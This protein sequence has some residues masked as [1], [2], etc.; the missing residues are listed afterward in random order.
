MQSTIR[1][2]GFTLIELLVVIAII[3]ILAAILFPV[4]AKAREKARQTSCLSNVKQAAL[5]IVMYVQDYDEIMVRH[6]YQPPVGG[7]YS[8]SRAVQPYAKND[9]MFMCPS[10]AVWRNRAMSCG[11]YGYNLSRL[12]APSWAVVG[13]TYRPMAQIEK[14]A[15]LLML[16]ESQDAG[17]AVA[18]NGYWGRDTN[19][20][21]PTWVHAT[22]RHNE[23]SNVGFGD[24]HAKWLK[25]TTILT[26]RGLWDS[27]YTQ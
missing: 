21:D 17:N 20:A 12:G 16:D 7:N 15:G 24:G 8:W 23:G 6:C 25:Q 9:Q 26:T 10:N 19:T 11:G 2:R 3:A 4:F 22:G 5:A 13:Y 27:R 1:K 14:P 18:W